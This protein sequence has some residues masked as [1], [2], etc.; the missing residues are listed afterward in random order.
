VE[1]RAFVGFPEGDPFS[2]LQN[3]DYLQFALAWYF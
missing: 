2:W 3:D 1:L